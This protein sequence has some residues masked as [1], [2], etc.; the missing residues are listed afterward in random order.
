MKIYT[1][2]IF[3]TLITEVTCVAFDTIQSDLL[4]WIYDY[5]F[6]NENN[7]VSL[8]NCGGWQSKSNFYKDP[9]FKP[10][11]EYILTHVES[12]VADYLDVKTKLNNMWINVNRKNDYNVSHTHGGVDLSGVFWIKTPKAS[13]NLIFESPNAF[14]QYKI[15]TNFKKNLYQD[16]NCFPT[17][18]FTP[19]E[20]VMIIFP[21]HLAHRVQKSLS[22][23][24][25]ISIAFNLDI[26]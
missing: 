15:F 5:K 20:G 10:F 24:E 6:K 23:D 14:V 3:P 8:S 9:T 2:P 17:Y 16:Y 26:I 13:G 11:L 18:S 7:G 1:F 21:A 4:E 19:T 12:G 22:E 25:R